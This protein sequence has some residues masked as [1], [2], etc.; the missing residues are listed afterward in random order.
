MPRTMVLS[1]DNCRTE[2]KGLTE[3]NDWISV[4]VYQTGRPMFY[5]FCCWDCLSDWIKKTGGKRE[6]IPLG[7]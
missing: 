7:R 2:N 3:V 6:L 5:T 4:K 1:C